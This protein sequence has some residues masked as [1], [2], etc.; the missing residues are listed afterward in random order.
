MPKYHH[1]VDLYVRAKDRAELVRSF[2]NT[3]VHVWGSGPWKRLCP[4][5]IVHRA[6]PFEK[7]VEIMKR[8]KL[9]LN[10]APRFKHGSHERILYGLACGCSVLTGES[11]F[12]SNHF[13]NEPSLL[14]YRYGHWQEVQPK[15]HGR[16]VLLTNHSWDQR[17]KT[18]ITSVKKIFESNHA[19]V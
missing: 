16:K 18:L 9:L 17:A 7:T 3:P 5:A 13:P 6:I 14:T 1:E 2:Q 15:Q 8:A 19:L 11:S 10:S 4:N 12:I